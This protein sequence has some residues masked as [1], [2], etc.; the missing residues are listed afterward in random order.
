MVLVVL[1]G[2]YADAKKVMVVKV[3]CVISYLEA[4]MLSRY[5][6]VEWSL[7]FG[8]GYDI[9]CIHFGVLLGSFGYKTV[10]AQ[11]LHVCIVVTGRV[12]EHVGE[13]RLATVN[14]RSDRR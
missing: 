3:G 1:G 9:L 2:I 10:H 12:D 14:R 13:I 4:L 11:R 8:T 7:S 6:L 5:K